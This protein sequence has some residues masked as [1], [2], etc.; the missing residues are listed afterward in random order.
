MSFRRSFVVFIFKF[1]VYDFSPESNVRASMNITIDIVEK[2]K[3][4]YI[5]MIC[6][7]LD[8]FCLTRSL[9]IAMA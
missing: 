6:H 7:L 8:V 1:W 9:S 5:E 2:I 3:D 4:V